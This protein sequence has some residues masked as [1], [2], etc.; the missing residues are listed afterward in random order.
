MRDCAVVLAVEDAANF[1][2][3]SAIVDPWVSPRLLISPLSWMPLLRGRPPER[4]PRSVVLV[5]LRLSGIAIVLAYSVGNPLILRVHLLL[6]SADI[7]ALV[8]HSLLIVVPIAE[9]R[10]WWSVAATVVFL[11]SAVAVGLIAAQNCAVS[12][13]VAAA[14]IAWV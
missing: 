1:S 8:I 12:G 6:P 14:W 13:L 3:I 9:W 2:R 10:C 5:L 11:A 7:A 4:K